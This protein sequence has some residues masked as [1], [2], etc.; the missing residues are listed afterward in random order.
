[1]GGKIKRSSALIFAAF[2]VAVVAAHSAFLNNPFLHDDICSIRDNPHLSDIG[3]IPDFFVDPSMFSC[4]YSRDLYRPVLLTTYAVNHAISGVNPWSWRLFNL[5]LLALNAFLVVMLLEKGGPDRPRAVLGGALFLLH[6][7]SGHCFRLVSTRSVLLM[8]LF[9]LLGVLI[10]L[11]A[12]KGPRWRYPL[13]GLAVV[14]MILGLLSV[15]AG[16]IFPAIILLAEGNKLRESPLT[17]TKRVAPYAVVVVAYLVFRKVF[18]GRTWGGH[19]AR[20]LL[21]N[22]GI[23]AKAWWLYLK[24]SLYPFRMIIYPDI[25]APKGFGDIFLILA[26]L[27]LLF[28]IFWG[29]RWWLSGKFSTRGILLLWAPVIYLPYAVVPLNVPVAYHHFYPSLAALAGSAGIAVGKLGRKSVVFAAVILVCFAALNIHHD[30]QWRNQFQW[31]AKTV[32]NSPESGRAWNELGRAYYNNENYVHAIVAYNLA[33][34]RDGTMTEIYHNLAGALFRAEKYEDALAALRYYKKHS[35]RAKD[36]P[37]VEGE[38]GMTLVRAG[39][40]GEALPYLERALEQLPY[41]PELLTHKAMALGDIGKTKEAKNVYSWVLSNYP[42]YPPAVKGR[43][44]LALSTGDLDTAFDILEAA[45]EAH[46]LNPDLA[47]LHAAAY[48]QYGLPEEALKVLEKAREKYPDEISLWFHA[49]RILTNIGKREKALKTY[50]RA[51]KQN[52]SVKQ[53]ERIKQIIESLDEK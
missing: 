44:R 21:V 16:I 7:V 48:L 26:V 50:R 28:W 49:G 3:N 52:F 47:H 19:L 4:L 18:L 22:L 35:P 11:R 42:G 6:P 32:R 38:I 14:C 9:I 45:E 8:F 5:L 31:A 30:L 46:G 25:E 23:Q 37:Y 27:G 17:V 20:P 10:H 39:R 12:F 53:K 1:M 36:S 15:S 51:L 40:P 43:I 33:L 41:D 34:Q 29:C 13:I 24:E 2:L